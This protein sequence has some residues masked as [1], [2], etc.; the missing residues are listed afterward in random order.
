V[1]VELTEESLALD[2]IHETGPDGH[3]LETEH[4]LRHVREMWTPVL[5]DRADFE[6]WS[7]KGSLT[8]QQKAKQ[9]DFASI[10]SAK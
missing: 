6:T 10:G 9:M 1:H 7:S 8:L 4:T 5:F 3:F 2:L